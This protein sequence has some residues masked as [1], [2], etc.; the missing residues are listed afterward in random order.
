MQQNLRGSCRFL[1]GRD[2]MT[3]FCCCHDKPMESSSSVSVGSLKREWGTIL[4]SFI[5]I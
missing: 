4:M 3:P 5:G 1:T 2:T